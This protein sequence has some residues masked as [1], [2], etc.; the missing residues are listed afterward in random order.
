M[1]RLDIGA[2]LYR[3]WTSKQKTAL[4]RSIDG[5]TIVHQ[6]VIYSCF[7][8]SWCSRTSWALLYI[9]MV[10][11]GYWSDKLTSCVLAQ[12]TSLTGCIANKSRRCLTTFTSKNS[13]DL[14]LTASAV[15]YWYDT[16]QR[17]T[18]F[19][20]WSPSHVH[21]CLWLNGMLSCLCCYLMITQLM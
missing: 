18:E 21:C 10:T 14:N 7:P 5:L 2:H 11:E 3:N 6:T 17:G 9:Q 12:L 1:K 4:K 8:A 19:T 20:K 16:R 13:T 15:F